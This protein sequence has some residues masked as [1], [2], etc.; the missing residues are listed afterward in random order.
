MTNRLRGNLLVLGQFALLA[1]L[2]FYPASDLSYG[3]LS[4]P[5]YAIGLVALFLGFLILAVAAL[6]L[7]KGL[8]AHPIPSKKG[9]L[10][11]SGL[12]RFVRHPIYTGVLLIGISLTLSGGLFPHIIFLVLLYLL[13]W[14]KARFEEQLLAARYREY[15]DYA[16]RTGRFF[17]RLKG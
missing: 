4:Y 2:V 7:G 9:E 3:S 1:A 14:Y 13:L 15:A 12:Y 17:P 8:T 16:S 6:A 5:V 10:V 11:V